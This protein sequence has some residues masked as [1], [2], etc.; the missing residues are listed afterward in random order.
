MKRKKKDDRGY[1][2]QVDREDNEVAVG[3]NQRI[4][5]NILY[6]SRNILSPKSLRH[7]NR[8]YR[9]KIDQQNLAFENLEFL[10]G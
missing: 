9:L 7:S 4:L 3:F 10:H 6:D 8:N 1:N 2:S 5:E